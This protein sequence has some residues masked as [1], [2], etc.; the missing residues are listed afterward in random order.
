M[1]VGDSGCG[2]SSILLRF[3]DGTFNSS[4]ISTIGVDFKVKTLTV[5]GVT[6]KLQI[7][8]TAGQERFRTIT[9]SFY[10]GAHGLLLIYDINDAKS[11]GNLVRWNTEADRYS[12]P[13]VTKI[14]VGNKLDQKIER[15]ISHDEGSNFAKELNVKFFE[16]SAKDNINIDD[17][18]ITLCKCLLDKA[19]SPVIK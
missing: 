3:T 14:I 10:R 13:S 4:F 11:F 8:D 7:W 17:V 15:H 5:D 16:V 6:C 19:N 12:L 18:F 9:S 2:K 1:L